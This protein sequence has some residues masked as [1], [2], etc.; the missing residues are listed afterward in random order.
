MDTSNIDNQFIEDIRQ[1]WIDDPCPKR[2]ENHRA[3]KRYAVNIDWIIEM[4]QE[5]AMIK[6]PVQLNA[7]NCLLNY[8]LRA[9]DI[10]GQALHQWLENNPN[11]FA[12]IQ[13]ED[14][15]NQT[16]SRMGERK[17]Y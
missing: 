11:N 12:R 9:F 1:L 14:L 5:F 17:I 15:L 6:T 2:F 3:L 7:L 16:L 4:M 10:F 13:I 8:G